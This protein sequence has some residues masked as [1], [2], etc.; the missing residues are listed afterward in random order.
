MEGIILVEK[1]LVFKIKTIFALC[2]MQQVII[3]DQQCRLQ[4]VVPSS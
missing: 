1:C 4:L 2:K 3:R